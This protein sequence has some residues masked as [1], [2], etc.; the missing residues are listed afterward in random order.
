MRCPTSTLLLAVAV[1]GA[2]VSAQ[3]YR[4][5]VEER[6]SA[7]DCRSTGQCSGGAL[8]S[9]ARDQVQMAVGNPFDV[10]R[11]ADRMFYRKSIAAIDSG[12]VSLYNQIQMSG[13]Q[14]LPGALEPSGDNR[15]TNVRSRK[16]LAHAGATLVD[17][18]T[19]TGAAGRGYFLPVYRFRGHVTRSQHPYLDAFV[20]ICPNVSPSR[21]CG[22]N[23]WRWNAGIVR[24]RDFPRRSFDVDELYSFDRSPDTLEFEF[25]VPFQYTAQFYSRI[26]P[27]EEDE[28]IL[29]SAGDDVTVDFVRIELQSVVIANAN[30]KPI[31]GVTVSSQSG[32][33]YRVQ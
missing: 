10:D 9:T 2:P 4:L 18:L 21:A 32:I 26:L 5:T 17:T 23:G 6:A 29:N 24:G 14:D 7:A 30:G 27:R 3:T 15:Q 33:S 1:L 11:V 31:K 12:G 16:I 22:P 25:G 20:F 8:T 28:M 19:V 13:S